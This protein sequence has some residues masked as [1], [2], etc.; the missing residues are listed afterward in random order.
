MAAYPIISFNAN[1]VTV[2]TNSPDLTYQQL[3]QTLNY[4]FYSIRKIYLQSLSMEQIN[5]LFTVTHVNQNGVVNTD[6]HQPF[7]DPKQ[8][9]STLDMTVDKGVLTIDNLTTLGFTILAGQSVQI[10]F[11]ADIYSYNFYLTDPVL[12][13]NMTD[14]CPVVIKEENVKQDKLFQVSCLV[15]SALIIALLLNYEH[16]KK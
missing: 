14:T 4:C 15:F 6:V 5:Q 8:Y 2:T 3:V 12:E 11:D 9:Q 10:E 1:A 16:G 13:C 7:V